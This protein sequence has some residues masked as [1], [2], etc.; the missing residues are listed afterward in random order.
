MAWHPFQKEVAKCN[1]DVCLCSISTVSRAHCT[2]SGRHVIIKAY[3]RAK[4]KP[5]NI[6]R[7][8]R[9]IALMRVAFLL[10]LQSV[11]LICCLCIIWRMQTSCWGLSSQ[12]STLCMV[13]VGSMVHTLWAG[14]SKYE[15]L[16]KCIDQQQ[17][18]LLLA[19]L[20]PHQVCITAGQSRYKK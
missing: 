4:M 19:C 12:C 17:Q 13:Q 5:K 10:V 11:H 15:V 18:T 8:D 9:E 6:T 3:E 20:L 2:V 16:D 1:R 7:M 14:P